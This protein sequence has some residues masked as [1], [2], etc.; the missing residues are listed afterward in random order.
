MPRLQLRLPHGW[1]LGVLLARPVCLT[2]GCSGGESL[3]GT[4]RPQAAC[5]TPATDLEADCPRPRANRPCVEGAQHT[6]GRS[7]RDRV[8]DGAGRPC[9]VLRFPLKAAQLAT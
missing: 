9:S 4:A 6:P 7:S 2:L 1:V 5:A 3:L 8:R